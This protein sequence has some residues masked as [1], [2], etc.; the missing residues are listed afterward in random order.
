MTPR[1][2]ALALLLVAPLASAAGPGR[3][4]KPSASPAAL[5]APSDDAPPVD[6]ARPS[7][8]SPG[9]STSAGPAPAPV[10][11]ALGS[12]GVSLALAP[13]P[14]ARD[15]G[16][17]TLPQVDLAGV[18]GGSLALRRGLAWG[19]PEGEGRLVAVCLGVD[20]RSWSDGAEGL[21]FGRLNAA[22]K[23]ELERRGELERYEEKPGTS[24]GNQFLQRYSASVKEAGAGERNRLRPLEAGAPRPVLLRAEGVHAVVFAGAR[25]DVV[26]CSVACVEPEAAAPARCAA[27]LESLRLE[28][29][30][31]APPKPDA[32]RRALGF[33]TRRPLAAAGLGA[34]GLMMALGLLTAAVGGQ[35]RSA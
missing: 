25:P 27:A 11:W 18:P 7:P 6:P 34:G 29:P 33:F 14:A 3:R 17:E 12:T 28:G 13:P 22:A 9:A 5:P 35:K 4:P 21:F 1:L 24:D 2:A 10:S 23:A 26:A 19:A 31:V 20:G 16:D 8:P 15:L 32:A 30:L